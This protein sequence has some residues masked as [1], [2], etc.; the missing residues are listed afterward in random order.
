MHCIRNSSV[1]PVMHPYYAC[2]QTILV[3]I[4]QKDL[5]PVRS[6]SNFHSRLVNLS[7]FLFLSNVCRRLVNRYRRIGHRRVVHRILFVQ[8]TGFRDHSKFSNGSFYIFSVSSLFEVVPMVQVQRP[9]RAPGSGLC[10]TP[11]PPWFRVD[12]RFAAQSQISASS[13][14]QC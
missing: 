10:R 5:G 8:R 11:Q 6:S 3:V 2:D 9:S 12:E 1:P 13:L 4:L 7:S 14:K